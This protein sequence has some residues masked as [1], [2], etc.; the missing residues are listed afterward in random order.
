MDKNTGR[1]IV[2][3]LRDIDPNDG[4]TWSA[5]E[6]IDSNSRFK[7]FFNQLKNLKL[8]TGLF[9]QN[10]DVV[11]RANYNKE[12]AELEKSIE[13]ALDNNL[14]VYDRHVRVEISD[15]VPTEKTVSIHVYSGDV[16]NSNNLLTTLTTKYTG[17][18][19]PAEYATFLK[20]LILD[21]EGNTRPNP[22]ARDFERVKWQVNYEDVETANDQSKTKEVRDKARQNLEDLYDDGVFEMQV[23]KLAYPSRSV[24]VTINP[25]MK[26][27]LYPERKAEPQTPA[28]AATEQ[29]AAHEVEGPAGKVDGDTG[30]ATE[31]PKREGILGGIP[32][33]I[34]DTINRMLEDSKTRVLDDGG[35]HY[36]IGGQLWSR[37]T[38]IKHALGGYTKDRFD[39]NSPWA[40]PSTAIGNSVDEFGRDVFN[41]VF[42]KM[43][44]EERTAAFGTYDNSTAKN[45]TEVFMALK[46]FEARLAQNGQVVI[47]TGTT[48][49]NPGHITAKGTLDVTV[50]G[51]NGIETKK[52]RVA[53]TLDVLA[54]D[55]DGNLHIYDFK[56]HHSNT[57][58]ANTAIEKG[59]DRQLSMYA[60]FLEDEY[61]LK[62][63]SINIL[64]IQSSYPAP[65]Q[66]AYRQ[67][68]PGGNQLE[69]TEA[70]SEQ[71]T[72]FEG[73]NFQVEKEIPLTRLS[74]EELVASFDKMTDAEKQAIVEAIQD[75]SDT[76]ATDFPVKEGD[77]TS[78]KLENTDANTF[79]EEEEE[80]GFKRRGRLGR[81]G[82]NV[83]TSSEATADAINPEDKGGMLNR[84]KDLEKACGGRKR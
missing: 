42:D 18:I 9:N 40:T 35:N 36:N 80:G 84:L 66:K 63:K 46:A 1:P 77:I 13:S 65:T 32:R 37:V 68:R 33:V 71:F 57:F 5:Q 6:V 75:Q 26:T 15:G 7:R 17:Q 41:G 70:G 47:A 67:S 23:T 59:Y 52:V 49:E 74:N 48:R 4:S 78:A 51:Q 83:D 43:A 25:A 14:T 82:L 29:H 39:P 50:K 20:D 44:E 72:A 16:N 28:P 3:V 60:K 10:G 34:I 64:P 61:G 79:E 54:I 73:A 69:I 62:V 12:I 21:K 56:T 58:D 53:G 24:T 27:K 19:S 22:E 8:P 11:N 2:D 55:G 31:A 81:R 76:P 38:P 45:Y 30:M